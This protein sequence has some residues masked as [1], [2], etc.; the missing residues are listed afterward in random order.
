MELR[1]ARKKAHMTQQEVADYMG[2]SRVTYGKFEAN[3]DIVSVEDA[4]KLS[5]LFKVDVSEI[6]F[7]SKL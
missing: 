1:E 4:K 3:S 6:F 5:K 2:I 7:G